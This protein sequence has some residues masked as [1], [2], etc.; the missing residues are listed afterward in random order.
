MVKETSTIWIFL[1]LNNSFYFDSTRTLDA[2]IETS[3]Y[4]Y[5]SFSY[6]NPFF[7]DTFLL[8]DLYSPTTLLYFFY[9]S[10]LF[11]NNTISVEIGI[12]LRYSF[13]FVIFLS[14]IML[15][16]DMYHKLVSNLFLEKCINKSAVWALTQHVV[17]IEI[18]S[19]LNKNLLPNLIC[20]SHIHLYT[21]KLAYK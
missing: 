12:G 10:F 16:H 8:F 1:L 21:S 19:S 6:R 3:K 5:Y 2:S 17:T 9:T 7:I 20:L 13:S 14:F 4:Y 15:N 18:K 11:T